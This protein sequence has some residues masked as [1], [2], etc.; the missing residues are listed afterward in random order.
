[1]N[2]LLRQFLKERTEIDLESAVSVIT[3]P[4]FFREELANHQGFGRCLPPLEVLQE[5]P[6]AA[7]ILQKTVVNHS[8]IGKLEDHKGLEEAYKRGWLQ[9][10]LN[11]DGKTHYIFPTEVHRL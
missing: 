9:A 8:F 3:N 1:M 10:E 4:K 5:K 2:Q 11:S 7:K 6:D